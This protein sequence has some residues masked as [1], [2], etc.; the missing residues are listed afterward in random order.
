MKVTV[1]GAAAGLIFATNVTAC[2]TYERSCEEVTV[3]AV[4][5]WDT[6]F[7]IIAGEVPLPELPSPSWMAVAA[8]TP[9]PNGAGIGGDA[10]GGDTGALMVVPR[11]RLSPRSQTESDISGLGGSG[12]FIC[13]DC[14]SPGPGSGAGSSPTSRPLLSSQPNFSSISRF[15]PVI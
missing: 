1:P 13:I 7:C 8:C 12:R 6:T 9:V 11:P 14:F 4:G 5:V 10:G 15:V 2:P 3:T